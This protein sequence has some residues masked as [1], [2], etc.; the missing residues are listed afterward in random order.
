MQYLFIILATFIGMLMLMQMVLFEITRSKMAKSDNV[1]WYLSLNRTFSY[2]R[3]GYMV[4]VCLVC[5]FISS[6][7]AMF[8]TAWFI[9]LIL[10]IAMGIV[11]DAIVQYMILIY[12][13]QRCK[14]EIQEAILLQNE[15]EQLSQTLMND[16]T[17]VKTPE[18]YDEKEILKKYVEP[19]DHLAFLSVDKGEFAK[20]YAPLPE[21]AFVVEP[22][23]ELESIKDKFEDT[24]FKV[25]KLTPS[26]QMP[27][28]DDKID[29]VMCQYSNYDKL[30]IHRVLKKDGYF[31]VNQNGTANLKEFLKIYMPYGMKGSW[32]AFSCAQTLEDIEMKVIEKLE[33]YGTIRFHSLNALHTYFKNNSPDLGD[34]NKYKIF[35]LKALKEI[36]ERS[37]YEMTTHRFLIVA[38]K[39]KNELFD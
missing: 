21:A 17:Y 13:K 38:Q 25:T 27:F 18:Q 23:S 33:D 28:K 35:Y 29:V 3:V 16:E 34:I 24:P 19:T 20:E 37:F 11:A 31:I 8:S 9:Y 2:N 12:G 6:P 39:V 1:N 26:G 30:E 32:D 36:K 14:K 15:L 10:F 22:Y 4:F 7:E 5:Y